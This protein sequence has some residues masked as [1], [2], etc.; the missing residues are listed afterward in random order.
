MERRL[1]ITLGTLSMDSPT[2]MSY[3]L[4]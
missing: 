1:H 4:E 2:I 3:S